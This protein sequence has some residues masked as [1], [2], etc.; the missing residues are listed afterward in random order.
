M[1]RCHQRSTGGIMTTTITRRWHRFISI[2]VILMQLL[3]L[4]QLGGAPSAAFASSSTSPGGVVSNLKLWLKADAGTGTTTQGATVSTWQ[5]QSGLIN[6]VT[7][8]GTP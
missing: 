4:A 2:V 5:D 3:A 7:A 8:A 1:H 6:D